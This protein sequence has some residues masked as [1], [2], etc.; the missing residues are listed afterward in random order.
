[1]IYKSIKLADLAATGV[2]A[3]TVQRAADTLEC[4]RTVNVE[5]V[6]GRESVYTGCCLAPAY[7]DGI[8]YEVTK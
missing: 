6:D 3:A 2:S 8:T 4:F 1:M 5:V 7:P